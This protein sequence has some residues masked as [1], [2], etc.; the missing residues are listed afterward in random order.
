MQHLFSFYMHEGKDMNATIG[1]L[2][3]GSK[4]ISKIISL[5]LN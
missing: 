5:L 1:D 2:G 3:A 4:R